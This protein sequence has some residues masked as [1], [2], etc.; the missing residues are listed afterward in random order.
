MLSQP[1]EDVPLDEYASR[2]EGSPHRVEV[3]SGA[4]R[5]GEPYVDGIRASMTYADPD[6]GIRFGTDVLGLE[7]LV[8]VRGEDG[9]IVHSEYRWP[10][11]G[12]IGISGADEANPFPRSDEHTSAL[13]SLMR[14]S[15]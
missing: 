7:E 6:A 5:D 4:T 11:G 8:L 9:G 1:I 10:G 12:I 2:S 15:Y 3:A 14:R 13:P